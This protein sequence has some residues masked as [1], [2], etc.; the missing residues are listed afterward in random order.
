MR[1]FMVTKEAI[2][3]MREAKKLVARKERM[4]A[5]TPPAWMPMLTPKE[6]RMLPMLET[7]FG[8]RTTKNYMFNCSVFGLDTILA[9]M[10]IK[11]LELKSSQRFSS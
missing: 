7:N 5:N 6:K 9:Q 3:L 11:I 2:F 8:V 4:R 10:E 1:D